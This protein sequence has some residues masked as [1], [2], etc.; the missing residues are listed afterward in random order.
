[1][2]YWNRPRAGPDLHRLYN[3]GSIDGRGE[4]NPPSNS[5]TLHQ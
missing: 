1:M 5:A 4:V 2:D 3:I